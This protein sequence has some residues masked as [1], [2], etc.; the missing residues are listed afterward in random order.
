[1]FKFFAGCKHSEELGRNYPDTA[2]NFVFYDID[3]DEDKLE[4]KETY[5]T[6]N[7][8]EREKKWYFIDDYRLQNMVLFSGDNI[9]YITKG[10]KLQMQ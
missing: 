9:I 8:T 4:M 10:D 3:D 6:K 1:M 5:I 7:N 2:L